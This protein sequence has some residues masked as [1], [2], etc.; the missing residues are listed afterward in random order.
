MPELP[1]VEHARRMLESALVG[2][3]VTRLVVHDA[4]V[5][6]GARGAKKLTEALVGR[7]IESVERRGKWL[8]WGLDEGA[9]FAHL[10]MTGKWL[11]ERSDAP[12]ARFE[13]LR[14]DA[15]KMH[16]NVSVRYVDA[17][18]LGRVSAGSEEP[19]AWRGLGPDAWTGGLDAE[20]LARAFDGRRAAVK[21]VLMDQAVVAGLGNIQA[22]EALFLAHIDPVRP[23]TSLSRP[24]VSALV[25]GIRRTLG[26]TLAEQ[27]KGPI[28]YVSDAGGP[29]PFRIYGRARRPCPRCGTSLSE[30]KLAGRTTVFCSACQ[31]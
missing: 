1:E 4:R 2:S 17:R 23:A 14:I 25:R 21:V 30:V 28:A 3:R 18:L 9:V 26:E 10:G 8:R 15:C 16:G 12:A 19:A 5:C 11:E 27:A 31:R 20:G 24:E 22:T 7:R 29:N 13:R 6:G